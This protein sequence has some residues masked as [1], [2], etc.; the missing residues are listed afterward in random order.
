MLDGEL[1]RTR[2]GSEK[3]GGELLVY[4]LCI[5]QEQPEMLKGFQVSKLGV[6]LEESHVNQAAWKMLNIVRAGGVKRVTA[7]TMDGS[8]HCVQLHYA[9]QDIAKAM[10]NLEVRHA[11]IE[12]G[13]LLEVTGGDV[14]KSRHLSQQK[15]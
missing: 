1:L 7:L 8:P 9:L 2:V 15:G 4:S 10:P 5:R 12:K 6:C 3:L 11:V 13:R 14:R